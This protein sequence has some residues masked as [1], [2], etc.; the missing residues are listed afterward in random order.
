VRFFYVKKY[1]VQ[2]FHY[3]IHADNFIFTHKSICGGRNN[4]RWHNRNTIGNFIENST[5]DFTIDDELLGGNF[6]N[7]D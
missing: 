4:K 5:E 7:C 1:S 3:N 6:G 2:N